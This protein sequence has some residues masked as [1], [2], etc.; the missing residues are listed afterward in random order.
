MPEIPTT[1]AAR[2]NSA[3]ALRGAEQGGATLNIYEPIGLDPW[4]GEGMTASRVAG[5][6]RSLN[7]R[8]VTVNINSPGGEVFEG[9]AIY[10][11]LREYSGN[12]AINVVGLAASIASVIAMA[13]NTLQVA[14]TGF[15]MVHNAWMMVVGNR[16]DM[17]D[18]AAQMEPFDTAIASVYAAKSGGTTEDFAALMDAETW[19]TG[20]QAIE[21]GLADGLL[22]SDLIGETEGAD[23]SAMAGMDAAE[24]ILAEKGLSRAD[25]RALIQNVKDALQAGNAPE[26]ITLPD[27]TAYLDR[28][29]ATVE[30]QV[31]RLH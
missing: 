11:Q 25:R 27:F 10:N 31:K 8:D 19:I 22:A 12:V 15:L 13:G 21:L 30:T 1:V 16:H 5:I 14:R 3:L 29:A 28:L 7:G 9:L 2:W 4:T 17:Q 20:Q 26:P 6:L 24:R 23:A 18:A